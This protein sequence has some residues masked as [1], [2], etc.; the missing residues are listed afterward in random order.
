[1]HGYPHSAVVVDET[2]HPLADPVA[3]IRQEIYALVRVVAIY[4]LTQT[5]VSLLHQVVL[6]CLAPV[7]VG[8]LKDKTAVLLPEPE[9]IISYV[10]P[11][12][13]LYDELLIGHNIITPTYY[14]I[15]ISTN[16]WMQQEGTAAPWHL[17]S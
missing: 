11:G 2:R 4:R 1:M 5:K 8:H 12:L 13:Y 3:S 15:S 16:A 9:H 6:F 14:W 7:S 17:S 10:D